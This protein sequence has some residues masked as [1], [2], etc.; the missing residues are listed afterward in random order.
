MPMPTKAVD[1]AALHF[2]L[3]E[4]KHQPPK[5]R[6]SKLPS[7]PASLSAMA[8]APMSRPW[9][10]DP[11]I[12]GPTMQATLAASDAASA[13]VSSAVNSDKYA[14][15][16]SQRRTRT[17]ASHRTSP[18]ASCIHR[19]HWRCGCGC[20]ELALIRTHARRPSDR[21]PPP[22]RS[23]PKETRK[24]GFLEQVVGFGI[25]K[26]DAADRR[27]MTQRSP[28]ELPW[29]IPRSLLQGSMLAESGGKPDGGCADI[30]KSVD[31]NVAMEKRRKHCAKMVK[32]RSFVP[33]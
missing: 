22:P 21:P 31:G 9:P 16:A 15:S 12:L 5:T 6:T 10:T 29:L 2:A 24:S 32:S 25:G 27:P 26:Y 7:I 13:S 17:A 20:S 33:Y 11:A 19:T 14:A 3:P 4:T 18:C 30:S 8:M 23:T 28:I 1:S